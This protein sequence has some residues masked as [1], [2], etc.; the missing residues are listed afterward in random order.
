MNAR[1]LFLIIY[2]ALGLWLRDRWW[3]GAGVIADTL[4]RFEDLW[5]SLRGH[6]PRV[7]LPVGVALPPPELSVALW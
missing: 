1:R 2:H 5:Q 4:W 7:K 6:Q 3:G